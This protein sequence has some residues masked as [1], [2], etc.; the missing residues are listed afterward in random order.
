MVK[1]GKVV[2]NGEEWLCSKNWLIGEVAKWLNGKVVKW[3]SG[4][5]A[6]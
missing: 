2:K 4:A 6:K 3:Q 1:S 5:V